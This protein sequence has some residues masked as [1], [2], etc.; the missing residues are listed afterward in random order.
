MI[1][2]LEFQEG[3]ECIRLKEFQ[4]L[5]STTTCNFQGVKKCNELKFISNSQVLLHD[6]SPTPRKQLYLSDSWFELIKT[7]Q[8]ILSNGNH[9]VFGVKKVC[10]RYLKKYLDETMKD[11]PGST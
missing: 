1:L 2:W 11:I 10:S 6:E 3:E 5:V 8:N 4:K 9:G 7:V